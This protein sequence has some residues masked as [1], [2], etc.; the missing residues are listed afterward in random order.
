M[1]NTANQE[2]PDT[3]RSGEA[4][5]S[6]YHTVLEGWAEVS[7]CCLA[8]AE[9]I[10]QTSIGYVRDQAEQFQELTRDP[11]AA[12]REQTYSRVINCSFDAAGKIAQAYQNSL[13]TVREPLMRVVSAQVPIGRA[14][15]GALERGMERGMQYMEKGSETM[16]RTVRGATRSVER[17]AEE[18]QAEAEQQHAQR[19]HGQQAGKRRSA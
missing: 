2:R 14:M 18:G 9:D 4:L 12:M 15:A 17:V 19:G 10:Y 7:K 13:E 16:E 6:Q 11:S 1:M 3:F 8:A 5:A